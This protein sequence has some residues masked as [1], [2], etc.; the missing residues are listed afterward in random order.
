MTVTAPTGRVEIDQF[1]TTRDGVDVH[2]AV[3]TNARGCRVAIL[4][5]GGVIQTLEV[6][7]RA[8]ALTNVALGFGS[9]GPY[10]TDSPYFGAIIGRFANRI[11]DARFTL[12]GVEHVLDRND[13]YGCVHGGATGFHARVWTMTPTADA[14][15]VGVRLE[16]LSPDGDNGFPG[17]LNVAVDYRLLDA[18]DHLQITYR[19]T[20]DAATVVNLTG[21]SYLN[22]AGE[23]SGSVLDHLLQVDADA[24]LPVDDA[25]VPTGEVATVA[26]TPFDFRT[27]HRIGERIRTSH[28][29]LVAGRGYDHNFVLR[30]NAEDELRRA[31]R[32]EEPAGGRTLEVWTT[33][34]GIDVYSG[35]FLDA[36]LVGTGGRIYRQ[37]DAIALEPEHFTD[38]PNRPEFPSTVLRPGEEYLSRTEYRF[39]VDG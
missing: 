19:A 8:G 5:Y 16:L 23:G 18:A 4:S 37:G 24:Y 15:G 34:P 22:L 17:N 30:A 21:H 38:S 6:P 10:E 9:F 33:E 25:L 11:R 27:P 28:A 2:R 20:T 13:E 7:D 32:V 3:L 1:G 29:Q 12:D 35:N 36:G 31:A 39:G 14:D 26:G